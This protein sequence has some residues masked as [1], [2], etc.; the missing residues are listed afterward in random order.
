VRDS[1]AGD[2]D[3]ARTGAAPEGTPMVEAGGGADGAFTGEGAGTE[4]NSPRP[5]PRPLPAG[6]GAADG[7]AG[8]RESG[9]CLEPPRR[10]ILE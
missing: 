9:C 6:E 7:G 5:R 8:W 4:E 1:A 3:A 10:D 2:G